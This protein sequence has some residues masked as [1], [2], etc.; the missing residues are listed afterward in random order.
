MVESNQNR[1]YIIDDKTS[2]KL[3]PRYLKGMIDLGF[4]YTRDLARLHA[5]DQQLNVLCALCVILL[6]FVQDAR[7]LSVQRQVICQY[8]I[9]MNGG[10]VAYYSGRQS[11]VALC[12]TMAETI[13]LAKLAVQS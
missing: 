7:T 9:V 3:A 13:A 4:R 6:Q 5:M 8:M 1:A 10:V 2:K 11:I 12:T